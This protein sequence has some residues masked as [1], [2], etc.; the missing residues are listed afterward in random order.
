ME[1]LSVIREARDK[2]GEGALVVNGELI[3]TNGYAAYHKRRIAFTLEK[4]GNKKPDVDLFE[5]TTGMGDTQEVR[6]EFAIANFKKLS[7]ADKISRP[8]FERM[9]RAWT[10]LWTRAK[11]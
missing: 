3:D 9:R 2:T 8:S 6:E 11:R 4:L 1:A 5:L 10:A 7:D